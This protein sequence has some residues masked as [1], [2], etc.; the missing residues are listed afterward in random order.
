MQ[1]F[2]SEYDDWLQ[3]QLLEATVAIIGAEVWEWGEVGLVLGLDLE[4]G[5][6]LPP[7]ASQPL[8]CARETE[9]TP[10]PPPPL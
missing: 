6:G 10:P 2:E 5:E 7:G 9:K 3:H 4:Q 8:A 1:I